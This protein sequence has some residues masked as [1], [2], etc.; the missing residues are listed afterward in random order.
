MQS[1]TLSHS[2]IV[3]RYFSSLN[4]FHFF[5]ADIYETAK[6]VQKEVG[7]VDILGKTLFCIIHIWQKKNIIYYRGFQ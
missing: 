7:K 1:H 4:F 6:K 3:D 5:S 2:S